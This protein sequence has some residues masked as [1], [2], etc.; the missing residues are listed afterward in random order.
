MWSINVFLNNNCW[1]ID[2]NSHTNRLK[3]EAV[4]ALIETL[5]EVSNRR[6]YALDNEN[7]KEQNA[8]TALQVEDE[9]KPP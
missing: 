3:G 4:D 7:A 1:L 8:L 2:F 6:W 5:P 9:I